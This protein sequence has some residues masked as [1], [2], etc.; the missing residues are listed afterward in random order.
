MNIGDVSRQ[1][2]RPAKTIRCV[3]DIGL[4]AHKT[5]SIKH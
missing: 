4:S 3:E 1:P 2:G 5:V